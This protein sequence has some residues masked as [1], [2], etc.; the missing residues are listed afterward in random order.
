MIKAIMACTKNYGIAKDGTL[1]WPKNTEDLRHFKKLTNGHI[2]VMGAKTWNDVCF[3]S[4]LPGRENYVVT[5]Q[6]SLVGANVI[7]SNVLNRIKELD[8]SNKDVWVIGGASII[9]QCKDIITEFHLTI[10]D[11]HFNCDTFL[12]FPF[13]LFDLVSGTSG[14][15]DANAPGNVYNIYRRR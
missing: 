6:D 14:A 4:P 2:V 10:I 12:N 5:H 8:N 1:P 3:P 9:E 7:N 11:G 15:S 13:E